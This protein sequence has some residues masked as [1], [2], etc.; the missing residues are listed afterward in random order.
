MENSSSR[1]WIFSLKK[2]ISKLIFNPVRNRLK[3]Q[4]VELDFSKLIFQKSS[5]DQQRVR[6]GKL[7]L[8]KMKTPQKIWYDKDFLQKK[9]SI[10]GL[11]R[12]F[13]ES[14]LP[15]ASFLGSLS[16]ATTA[17]RKGTGHWGCALRGHLLNLLWVI[18]A[19]RFTL[20]LSGGGGGFKSSGGSNCYLTF[21]KEGFAKKE[22]ILSR[23]ALFGVCTLVT[24]R[25]GVLLFCTNRTEQVN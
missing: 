14:C 1:N 11:T 21:R 3:I 25:S 10:Y 16:F 7:G 19:A 15:N 20:I 8:S 5:T 17:G 2:S 22:F 23:W 6:L 4:F 18:S 9:C 24:D 12:E 13:I